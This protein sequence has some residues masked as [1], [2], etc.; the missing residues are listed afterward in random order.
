MSQ[1]NRLIVEQIRKKLMK[2]IEQNRSEYHNIDVEKVETNDWEIERFVMEYKTE[3]KTYEAL[4]RALKWKKWFGVHD[5]SDDYFPKEFYEVFERECFGRDRD[6]RLIQWESQ[7]NDQKI[8]GFQELYKQFLAHIINRV[9]REA[10]SDGFTLVSDIR[11]GGLSV[12]NME[13]LN[14]RIELFSYYPQGLRRVVVVDLPLVLHALTKLVTSWVPKHIT[15]RLKFV[16]R[17]GLIEFIE[18]DIIPI[19]MGG[20]RLELGFPS[21]LKSITQ[22]KGLGLTDKQI[23]KFLEIH[24][25]Y[26]S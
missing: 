4:V 20:P 9:D 8:S 5:R 13:F 16:R 14:F 11:G 6:G 24:K 23:N 18:N 15:N 17:E 22:L 25:R 7:R 2:E 21:N 3:D 12:V 19:R 26:E 10:A 1:N